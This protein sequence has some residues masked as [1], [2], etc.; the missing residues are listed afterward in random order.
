MLSLR[1]QNITLPTE[2][3]DTYS[4]GALRL[5][6]TSS[7]PYR[8]TLSSAT[9]RNLPYWTYTGSSPEVTSHELSKLATIVETD[10][11]T[12]AKQ[13]RRGWFQTACSD[14]DKNVCLFI[15]QGKF[16]KIHEMTSKWHFKEEKLPLNCMPVIWIIFSNVQQ[17]RQRCTSLW[18]LVV[19]M[20]R[21][22]M[23]RQGLFFPSRI[24]S[25]QAGILIISCLVTPHCSFT[26]MSWNT[27]MPKFN[28]SKPF[29][30]L[31]TVMISS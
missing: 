31:Q 16:T 12:N 1:A 10:F 28:D 27:S 15:L 9:K 26:S 5:W 8:I 7:V 25:Q 24:S 29:S 2:T 6:F 17:S 14:Q 3:C 18:T 13:K 11:R 4:V 19:E 30:K 22:N 21:W 23:T 20:R